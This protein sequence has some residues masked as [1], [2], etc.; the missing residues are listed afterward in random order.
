MNAMHLCDELTFHQ[1]QV[2]DTFRLEKTFAAADVDHFAQVSG[3]FSPL[4]MDQD[5][6]VASGFEGRVVH[7]MLLAALFSQLVG[8]RIPGRNALYLAQDLAFRRPVRVGECVTALARVIGKNPTTQTILLSTEIR[9]AE[10]QVA[11]GGMA[12]VK[13]RDHEA[14]P[15]SPNPT[16]EQC[17][18]LPVGQKCVLI[19]GATGGVGS[20]IATLLAASGWAVGI[21]Y[22][23]NEEKAARMVQKIGEAGGEAFAIQADLREGNAVE[24]LFQL[25]LKRFARL[26]A[27]VNAASG[28]IFHRPMRDLEWSQ[29]MHHLDFQ[30][31]AVHQV[32]RQAFPH[33]KNSGGSVVNILSQVVWDAPP[34]QMADYVA[35]KYAL[36]GFSKALAV[37]WAEEGIRVNTVSPGLLRTDMT[38]HLNERIFK[39]E[40]GR[41]PL[42]RLGTPE[43][44]ART[45]AF[46]LGEGA[47]FLTGVDLPLTGGQVM[48]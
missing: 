39:S 11:V 10:D 38:E 28:E 26:D 21:H 1:I 3:D 23:Q 22:F 32:C 12:R 35:A 30:L 27:V 20:A 43:D 16:P 14:L 36:K 45:V 15:E 13:I 48:P 46:L 18:P 8:M 7:G 31:K 17:D 33:L 34:A 47:A 42:R 40:I 29:F 25:A 2:G 24:R 44:V 6:A 41:T 37:E 19:T 9:N 4:H 5:Y